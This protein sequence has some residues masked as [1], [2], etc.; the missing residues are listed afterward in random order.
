MGMAGLFATGRRR[1]AFWSCLALLLV[2]FVALAGM[3]ISVHVQSKRF[4]AAYA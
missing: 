2:A 3:A 1:P 4:P